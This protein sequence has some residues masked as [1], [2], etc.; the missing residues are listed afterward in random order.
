LV[1][2][3]CTALNN[4][5]WQSL[6]HQKALKLFNELCFPEHCPIGA[7]L[8][9]SCLPFVRARVLSARVLPLQTFPWFDLTASS[10][11]EKSQLVQHHLAQLYQAS[12][13]DWPTKQCGLIST[14]TSLTSA[15]VEPDVTLDD[16]S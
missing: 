5:M 1:T 9:T 10:L 6:P 2:I 3:F 7:E 8:K 15:V 4:S 16:K 12:F 11:L 13:G 14:K